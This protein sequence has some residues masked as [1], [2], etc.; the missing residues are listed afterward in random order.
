MIKIENIENCVTQSIIKMMT[1]LHFGEILY[2][3]K[4]AIAN[5]FM[6]MYPFLYQEYFF[7]HTGFIKV[8]RENTWHRYYF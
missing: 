2:R 4:G 8:N 5:Y 1:P 7:F 6:R 3:Y